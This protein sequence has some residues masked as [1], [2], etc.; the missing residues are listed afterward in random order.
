MNNPEVRFNDGKLDKNGILY[1]GTMDRNEQNFIGNIF[2]Y[3]NSYLETIKVI[4]ELPMV[5]HLIMR[6]KCIILIH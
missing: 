3:E 2:R 1:I 4:L 6:I 5:Y